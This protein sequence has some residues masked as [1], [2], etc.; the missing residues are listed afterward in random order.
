M[1]RRGFLWHRHSCRWGVTLGSLGLRFL[2]RSQWLEASSCFRTP[3]PTTLEELVPKRSL[4][5]LHLRSYPGAA[6]LSPLRWA[7]AT[8]RLLAVLG[9]PPVSQLL[10]LAAD[11]PAPLPPDPASTSHTIEAI[12][13]RQ[14]LYIRLITG[15]WCNPAQIMCPITQADRKTTRDFP[16]LLRASAS[17]R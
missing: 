14:I 7:T 17:P 2:A 12:V 5:R 10:L 4:R 6:K 11:P 3:L 1:D 15:G 9:F 16:A 13:N 8:Q